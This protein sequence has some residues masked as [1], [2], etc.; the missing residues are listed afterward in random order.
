[1]DCTELNGSACL[2]QIIYLDCLTNSECWKIVYL[3]LD[4]TRLTTLSKQT[5]EENAA[6][7]TEWLI[8]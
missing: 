6:I 5:K 2:E 8:F 7:P 1:M 4:A 3:K